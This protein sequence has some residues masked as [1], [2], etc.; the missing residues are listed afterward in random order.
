[1]AFEKRRKILTKKN[2]STLDVLILF[3]K[4]S[5]KNL[6]FYTLI[7]AFVLTGCRK[8]IDVEEIVTTPHTPVF[9]DNYNPEISS[10]IA[11]VIGEVVDENGEPIA[12]ATITLEGTTLMTNTFG[13]FK[14]D[15]TTMNE[16]GTFVQV[17][18]EG[19]FLSG[20]RFYP[21]EG[22]QTRIRIELLRKTFDQSFASSTGATVDI[23][24][25]GGSII[26]QANSIRI[27]GGEIYTGNVNVAVRYLNPTRQSTLTQMPGALEGVNQSNEET[28]MITYGMVAVELE[29]E[30]GEKLNIAEGYT[31]ILNVNIP[32]EI[33]TSAPSEIPLWSFNYTYGVWVEESS[34]TLENGK[35]TGE[36]THFSFW[37]CDDPVELVGFSL[38]VLDEVNNEPIEGLTVQL[39]ILNG[40]IG[41]TEI[42][43]STGVIRGNLPL[44]EQ[45]LLEIFDPCGDVIYSDEIGP[46]S[47]FVNLGIVEAGSSLQ[48][49]G[50]VLN[51]DFEN[52]ESTGLIVRYGDNIYNYILSEN[53]FTLNLPRCVGDVDLEIAGGDLDNFVQ[54]DFTSFSGS[55]NEIDAG[56]VLACGN[57]LIGF[58]RVTSEGATRFFS[59]N[60]SRQIPDTIN[61]FVTYI[62]MTSQE[63]GTPGEQLLAQ[64]GFTSLDE[65]GG[66]AAGDYSAEDFIDIL[67]D[68]EN[69]WYF[70]SN[71]DE[72]IIEEYGSTTNTI[73][74]GYGSGMLENTFEGGSVEQFVEFEF[75]AIRSQ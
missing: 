11:S 32:T 68:S 21:N 61:P 73:I 72:F 34:A 46:F 29:G 41:G 63:N 10:V 16:K 12:N 5:M 36:V 45:L 47:S 48:I 62:D 52:P 28:G 13:L 60:N 2:D 37:N 6:I 31:A 44:D 38:T 49:S 30:S 53:P 15:N 27:E 26:F 4:F 56:E 9:I 39:S 22:E 17:E 54:G 43:N 50:E 20:R 40:A 35:Y 65:D 33:L 59:I 70:T 64:F 67:S 71:F 57:A 18:K 74:S 3:N 25:G 69:G 66:F 75:L 14:F 24:N 42:T 7:F 19:Y 55:T 51:C 8:E 23:P 1:M 58:C